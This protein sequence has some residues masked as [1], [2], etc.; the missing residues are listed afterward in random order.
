MNSLKTSDDLFSWR[1]FNGS[2]KDAWS[3]MAPVMDA[4]FVHD[5]KNRIWRA[6]REYEVENEEIRRG[7]ELWCS[8]RGKSDWLLP[9][10][11][12]TR[13]GKNEPEYSWSLA[14]TAKER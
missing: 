14:S 13:K 1:V 7:W 8:E 11:Q 3:A 10:R 6:G 2:R 4:L 9:R 5:S 12:T